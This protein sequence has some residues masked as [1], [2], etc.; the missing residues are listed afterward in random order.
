M[1]SFS[2]ARTKHLVLGLALLGAPAVAQAQAG[3][4]FTGNAQACFFPDAGTCVPLETDV[5]AGLTYASLPQD[6]NAQTN[7]SGRAS[8]GGGTNNFGSLLLTSAPANYNNQNLLLRLFFTA[9]TVAGSTT[10]SADITGDVINTLTGI[11]LFFNPNIQGPIAFTDALGRT[12]TFS[13]TVNNLSVNADETPTPIT[14]FVQVNSVVPEPISMT[15]L[16]TGLF[17]V[18]GAARRRRKNEATEA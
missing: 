16:G 15:L 18:F 1:N 9:P 11:D 14:G 10:F 6:F 3:I 4:Q 13:V 17:G 12:G 8:F 7:N 2:L 5:V